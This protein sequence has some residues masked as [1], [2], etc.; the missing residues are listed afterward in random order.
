MPTEAE[1]LAER[2]MQTRIFRAI[3]REE[4]NAWAG[5]QQCGPDCK[6]L[7]CHCECAKQRR[8]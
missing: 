1:E 5:N 8:K 7:S 3:C 6:G 2:E 4:I